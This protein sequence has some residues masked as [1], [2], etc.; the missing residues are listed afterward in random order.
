[1]AELGAHLLELR[2]GE[3]FPIAKKWTLA[4]ALTPDAAI[5]HL[6]SGGNIGVNLLPSRMVVI[7]SENHVATTALINAGFTPTVVPAKAQMT[8]GH[9]RGGAHFWLRLPD[10][11]S[12]LLDSQELK[13]DLQLRV[14]GRGLVD[15]LAGARQAV[16]PPSALAEAG[17]LRYLPATGGAL[18]VT[19]PTELQVAP[20][21]L[22]DLEGCFDD[23]HTIAS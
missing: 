15:V 16:A 2:S 9:K 6:N 3:K 11:L 23:P 19:S 10:L 21:W 12:D 7:D 18:D 13:S 5:A 17:G 4:P 14:A 1:M 20:E 22:F 8:S